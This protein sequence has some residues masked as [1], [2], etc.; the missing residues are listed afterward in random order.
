MEKVRR[1]FSS[2]WWLMDGLCK[3]PLPESWDVRLVYRGAG[4]SLL[5]LVWTLP[6]L[7]P[8]AA[9]E[10][11]EEEEE[12]EEED[13]EGDEKTAKELHWAGPASALCLPL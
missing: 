5:S 10:E 12:K 2:Y 9:G 6:R 4:Y 11:E 3:G 8:F 7:C 13:E 1:A